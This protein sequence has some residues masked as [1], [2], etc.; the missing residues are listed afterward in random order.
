VRVKNRENE[1]SEKFLEK[2]IHVENDS[3]F[4]LTLM[5][6]LLKSQKNNQEI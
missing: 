4:S 6:S 3:D 1:E 5:W 2:G